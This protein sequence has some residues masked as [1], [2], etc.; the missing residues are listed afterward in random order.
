MNQKWLNLCNLLGYQFEN[1]DILRQALTHKSY[2]PHE[3]DEDL[4]LDELEDLNEGDNPI[5]VNH[6]L[7]ENYLNGLTVKE[8]KGITKQ[9][10]LKTRGNK[11]EL[12]NT[13][14]KNK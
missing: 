3:L 4:D 2:I 8:L 12:I 10:G 9:K 7:N 6:D 13:I 5:N 11:K 1:L 14:L